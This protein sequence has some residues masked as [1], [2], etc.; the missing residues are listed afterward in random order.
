MSWQVNTLSNLCYKITDGTHDSPK[1]VSDGF[2]YIK[3]THVKNGLI[4]FD[5]CE[6]LD[7]KDHLKVVSRSKPEKGDILFA[8]IG[9]N[10]GECAYVNVDFEFSIKNVALFKPD[11]KYLNGKFLYYLLSSDLIQR[12]IKNRKSGSAQPFLS[13]KVLRNYKIAYPPIKCQKSIADILS[14]YDDL[15]ANNLK[16]IKLLEQASQNIYKE[17]FVNMRFPGY[18]NTAINAETALPEGWNKDM[19]TK[20]FDFQRGVEVGSK[21]YVSKQSENTV[22]FLRVGS[23]KERKTDI[24]TDLSL[25]KNRILEPR[26]LCVSMDGSIGLVGFGLSGAYSS[27]LQ[28]VDSKDGKYCNGFIYCLL[29]SDEIQNTIKSYA[30]GSTILH[31]SSSIKHMKFNNA[32]SDISSEF[33]N[34]IEPIFSQLLILL[35]ENNRLKDLRDILLPLL[36]NQTIKV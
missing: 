7:E 11:T 33:N 35:E 34:I 20:Y 1:S 24:Y 22:P 17:W 29:N 4:D 12:D 21:N 31:A 23:L 13:L 2:P 28:K 19:V 18:Q 36:M 5:N 3:G 16:R 27:G 32:P 9:G 14:T 25:V 26:D 6:Y 8:N 15:I 10:I 30:K